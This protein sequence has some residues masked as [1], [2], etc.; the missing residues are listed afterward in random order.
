MIY[1]KLFWAFIK[2]GAFSIGGGY[3]ALPLIKE[4]IV[5]NNSW[6]TVDEYYDVLT[7]SQMTPGPISINAATFVGV[8]VAGPLGAI[9]ATLGF[10]L[11]SALIITAISFLYYKYRKLSSVKSVLD[12]LRPVTIG[13]IAFAGFDVILKSFWITDTVTANI[14][15]IN[16]FSVV[17]FTLCIFILRKYKVNPILI[18]LATGVIGGL[19]YNI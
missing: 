4:Q 13:L 9:I 6:I 14:M 15:D 7:I 11:P 2:V 17:L 5:A 12:G 16:I 3:A 8:K 1:L 19:Y 10:V 18:I